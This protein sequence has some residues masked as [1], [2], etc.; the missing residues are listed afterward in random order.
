MVHPSGKPSVF[1]LVLTIGPE[2]DPRV[3]KEAVLDVTEAA[4]EAAAAAEVGGLE[5]AAPAAVAL[6]LPESVS[7]LVGVELPEDSPKTKI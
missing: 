5:P 2:V 1:K 4:A 3:A 6:L 7:V